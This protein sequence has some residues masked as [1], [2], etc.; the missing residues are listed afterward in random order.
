M[1]TPWTYTKIAVKNAVV[2]G[3]YICFEESEL[4][5]DE[6][7]PEGKEL[8]RFYRSCKTTDYSLSLKEIIERDYENML[9]KAKA[10]NRLSNFISLIGNACVGLASDTFDNFVEEGLTE[11]VNK[12]E[13][14]NSLELAKMQLIAEALSD[15]QNSRII[16]L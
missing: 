11:I 12:D 4:D 9:N 13:F 7:S 15:Y 14:Y 8:H 1:S 2:V 5:W 10:F 6:I 16:N 3:A